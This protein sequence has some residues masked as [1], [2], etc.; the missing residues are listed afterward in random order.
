MRLPWRFLAWAASFGALALLLPPR[1]MG[2]P[3]APAP[4]A[5]AVYAPGG[6][7]PPYGA[8]SPE[9]ARVVGLA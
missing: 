5:A 1:A 4:D 2:G 7:Q 9:L 8:L 6:M 3:D